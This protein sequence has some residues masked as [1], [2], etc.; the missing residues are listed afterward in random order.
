LGREKGTEERWGP[1]GEKHIAEEDWTRQMRR[2]G[3]KCTQQSC[4]EKNK[5]SDK[6]RRKQCSWIKQKIIISAMS[7]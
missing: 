2:C 4:I 1:E 3:F 5:R 6:S 7:G